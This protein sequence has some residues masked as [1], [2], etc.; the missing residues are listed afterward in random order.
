MVNSDNYKEINIV[1]CSKVVIQY[2]NFL[3]IFSLNGL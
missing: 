1:K 3:R 2:R